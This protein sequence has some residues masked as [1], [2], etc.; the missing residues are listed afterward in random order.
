MANVAVIG[1]GAWGTTLSKV[2]A[3]NG[4]TPT[5][6]SHDEAIAT[7]INTQHENTALLAGIKL[8]EI[9]SATTDL[10]KAVKNSSLIL[11]VT[12]SQYFKQTLIQ[13]KPLLTDQLIISATKGLHEADDKRMSEVIT[14]VLPEQQF[15]ILS[16]PNISWEIANKKPATTVIASTNIDTAKAIQAYFNNDYFRVYVNT[17]VIGTEYGGTLKNVIAIAAGIIDG[18]QLGDNTKAALMVRGMVEMTRL[19]VTLGAKAETLMGLTG[20]GDL[21]TTCSSALSRNHTVGEKLATGKTI[22]EIL[23]EMKA[24][25]EGVATTKAAYALAQKYQVE[26]PITEQMYLVLYKDKSITE[27][28]QALMTRSPKAEY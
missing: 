2:L 11:I 8:P 7:V 3:D 24:V 14:E 25:A 22:K 15:G 12:A 9:I 26:M 16:G 13:L 17:D 1:A 28:L 5:I 4:H 27:A 6:W 21:I 18:L 23:K 10:A 19:A 20:M